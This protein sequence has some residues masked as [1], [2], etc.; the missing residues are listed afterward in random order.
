MS[1]TLVEKYREKVKDEWQRHVASCDWTLRAERKK[2]PK[3]FR[4]NMGVTQYINS[5]HSKEPKMVHFLSFG[6]IAWMV[7]GKATNLENEPAVMYKHE[8]AWT[9]DKEQEFN[10]PNH[11]PPHISKHKYVAWTGAYGDREY[12]Y[13]V[14]FLEANGKFAIPR[15]NRDNIEE[16]LYFAEQCGIDLF[17]PTEEDLIMLKIKFPLDK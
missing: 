10:R 17:N 11:L 8:W 12:L 15:M 6:A 2:H 3:Y 5:S 16:Y 1:S 7:N 13:R 4:T 9:I 14:N